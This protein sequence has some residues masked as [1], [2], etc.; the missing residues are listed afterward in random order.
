MKNVYLLLMTL[1]MLAATAV[2]ANKAEA[3]REAK[4]VELDAAC[5][6]ARETKLAIVRADFAEECVAIGQLPDLES[7]EKFYA[8]YGAGGFNRAPLFYDLPECE[9]AFEYLNSYRNSGR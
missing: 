9:I 5:E 4:Q 7:C 8:D 3:E 1:M 2:Q 6:A